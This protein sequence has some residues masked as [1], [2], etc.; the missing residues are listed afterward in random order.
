MSK[1]AHAGRVP[2]ALITQFARDLGFDP[3]EVQSVALDGKSVT[4]T[5]YLLCECHG[6]RYSPDGA[7]GVAT[8]TTEVE[9]VDDEQEGA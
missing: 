6:A 8:V 1:L 4:V 2:R 7:R 3:N 9:V 5:S